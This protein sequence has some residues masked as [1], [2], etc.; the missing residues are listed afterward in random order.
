MDG[1]GFLEAYLSFSSKAFYNGRP[2]GCSRDK[3][4]TI[5]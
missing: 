2:F 1:D 4:R 3:S 5:A